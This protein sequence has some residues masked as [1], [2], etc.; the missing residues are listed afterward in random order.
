MLFDE[1][2]FPEPSVFDP[3]RY[4]EEQ[5]GGQWKYIARKIDPRI[6]NFGYGRR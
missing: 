4:L 2:V 3:E 6:V 5:P 1:E